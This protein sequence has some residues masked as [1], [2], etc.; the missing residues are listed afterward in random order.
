VRDSVARRDLGHVDGVVSMTEPYV[1]LA[2]APGTQRV[3]YRSGARAAWKVVDQDSRELVFPRAADPQAGEALRIT[4]DGRTTV[5]PLW[6]GRPDTAQPDR[7]A[8]PASGVPANVL[9]WPGRGAVSAGPPVAGVAQAYAAAMKAPKAEVRRLFSGDT[10]AGVRFVIAQAWV[11][12]SPARTVGYVIQPGGEAELKIQPV[13]PR[14]PRHRPP[15]DRSARQH[16]RHPGGRARAAH[17]PTLL[18]PVRCRGLAV[19]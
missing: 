3:E 7:P 14:Q 18:P 9:L 4:R 1:V 5:S 13:T 12:G 19:A 17:D 8:Q 2:P 10:D 16:R 6:Q 11:P 15:P